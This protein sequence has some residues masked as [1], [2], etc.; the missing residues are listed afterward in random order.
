M[1]FGKGRVSLST[2]VVPRAGFTR[3]SKCGMIFVVNL[4]I[5]LVTPPVGLVLHVLSRVANLSFERC[6]VATLP[7]LVPMLVALLLVTF[8]PQLSL[9]LPTLLFR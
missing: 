4:M 8:I 9:F 7:F 3:R 2:L 5:G 6:V 1:I